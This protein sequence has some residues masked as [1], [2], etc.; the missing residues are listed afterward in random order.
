MDG[1]H[2]LGGRPG[3][4]PVPVHATRPWTTWWEQAAGPLAAMMANLAG[5]NG[6]ALRHLMECLPPDEY[7]RLSPAG[8]WVEVA[9]RCAVDAGVATP[10]ELEDRAR[11]RAEGL[12]PRPSE[13]YPEPERLVEQP[14]R[15]LAHSKRDPGYEAP[16]PWFRPGQRVRTRSATPPGHTRL[17]GYLRGRPGV[18]T[19]VN[20]Y[21]VYPDANAHG[22]EEEATWVYTVRFSAADLWPAPD[23]DCPAPDHPAPDHAAPDHEVLADLFEPYLL[24]VDDPDDRAD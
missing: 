5:V 3:F 20:G 7:R 15:R 22:G 1:P 12:R 9:V 2:D 19:A 11:R 24:E 21:W 16:D 10:A 13:E 4:G 18:V 23:P 6:D 14:P 17:A 8:R